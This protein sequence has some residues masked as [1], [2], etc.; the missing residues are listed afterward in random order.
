LNH[1]FIPHG[2]DLGKVANVSNINRRR[3]NSS[4]VAAGL[5]QELVDLSEHLLRLTGDVLAGVVSNLA[6]QVNGVIANRHLGK[7]RANMKPL[8]GHV[9]PLL[10]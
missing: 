3:K 7:A 9:I 8:D 4:L 5:S 1:P 6:C 10:F 2:I